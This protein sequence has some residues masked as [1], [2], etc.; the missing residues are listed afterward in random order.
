MATKIPVLK[1]HI[2]PVPLLSTTKPKTPVQGPR[3]T[4]IPDAVICA[5]TRRKSDVASICRWPHSLSLTTIWPVLEEYFACRESMGACVCLNFSTLSNC[6]IMQFRRPR[7]NFTQLW[8]MKGKNPHP[9]LPK[10]SMILWNSQP[11]YLKI[12]CNCNK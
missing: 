5:K 1:S 7:I 10:E 11:I 9:A 2:F 3:P 8:G 12:I 6:C 4:T